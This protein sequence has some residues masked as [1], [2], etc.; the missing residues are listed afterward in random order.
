MM[1][2]QSGLFLGERVYFAP[3]FMKIAA[4]LDI[5]LTFFFFNTTEL[6]TYSQSSGGGGGGG[7]DHNRF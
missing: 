2:V 4:M 1:F 5:C 3:T 7:G 6:T